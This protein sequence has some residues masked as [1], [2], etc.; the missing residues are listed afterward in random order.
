M[1]QNADKIINIE[2]ADNVHV[3]LQGIS[4]D[5][6]NN[7]LDL[8]P[9]FME[10]TIA[11]MESPQLFRGPANRTAARGPFRP[12]TPVSLKSKQ[13]NTYSPGDVVL[14]HWQ[15]DCCIGKGSIGSV[16]EAHHRGHGPLYKSAIKVISSDLVYSMITEEDPKDHTVLNGSYKIDQELTHMVELRGTG[17]IVDY[18]DHE[19]V[20]YS[21]GSWGIIIRMELLEPLPNILHTKV[22]SSDE[23]IKIGIDICKA[24]EFC[25]KSN[26]IH[27]DVK[28][29]NIYVTKWGGYKLGDFS[30]SVRSGN[31]Q[32]HDRIGTLKYMAPEVYQGKPFS[33][34]IDTY[35]LGLVLYELLRGNPG[36]AY[37]QKAFLSRLSGEPLHPIP[38]IDKKLESII[39][40]ACA[41][42]PND[43]YSTPTEMLNDL[44]RLKMNESR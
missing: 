27:C 29:S 32:A 4:A 40:K 19:Q 9:E 12:I 28:P 25:S 3:D 17:Y 22:M 23:A 13:G 5:K 41:F 6:L 33:P 1:N 31:N 43:R 39:F 8:L 14:S 10:C 26:I 44:L 30:A 2:H 36:R 11:L 21:D 20:T 34:S 18:E 16:Y 24:L 37:E 35:S 42:D 38:G 15:I 7:V